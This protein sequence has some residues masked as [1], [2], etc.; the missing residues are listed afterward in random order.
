MHDYSKPFGEK[1]LRFSEWLVQKLD[2][3]QVP[4]V[5]WIDRNRGTFTIPW[6][7]G[8]AN[9]WTIGNSAIFKQWAEH[10]GKHK[11]GRNNPDP[12]KWKTNFRCTLNA[13]PCFTE[14]RERSHPRGPEAFKIFKMSRSTLRKLDRKNR[15]ETDHSKHESPEQLSL[16]DKQI[17]EMVDEMQRIGTST[18][19]TFLPSSPL[20]QFPAFETFIVNSQGCASISCYLSAWNALAVDQF[21]ANA[22]DDT[23]EVE[24]TSDPDE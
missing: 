6:K 8:S 9:G 10:S 20:S 24:P 16:A 18:E 12:S 7:H 21:V 17:I 1:K 4:G 15:R 11:D 22:K 23:H 2:E 19:K 3:N 5:R 13:L 14:I